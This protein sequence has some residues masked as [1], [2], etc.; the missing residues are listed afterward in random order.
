MRHARGWTLQI[1]L[2][3]VFT[4]ITSLIA[5]GI[6]WYGHRQMTDLVALEVQ[7]D[8]NRIGNEVRA[9]LDE[10]LEPASVFLHTLSLTLHTNVSL[11]S[12]AE[13]LPPLLDALQH[14][15]PSA[16]SF[17][18]GRGDGSFAFVQDLTI[19]VP[20]PLEGQVPA[21]AA[22]ALEIVRID[23]GTA[24][25]HWTLLDEAL[26]PIA[27]IEP[28][29]TTFDPRERTWFAQA[30]AAEGAVLTEVYSF[31]H[32][33][34]IGLTMARRS[35]RLGDAIL[36]LDILLTELDALLEA[37]R[38]SPSMELFLFDSQGVLVAH[39]NGGALREAA[40]QTAPDRLP[41]LADLGEPRLTQLLHL[42]GEK[43][44][45]EDLIELEGRLHLVRFESAGRR[46]GDLVLTMAYPYDEIV[47]PADS[48]RTQMR[49]GGFL[50]L[51]VGFLF[52][53][54][55][56]R[57]VARPLRR[58]T[59]DMARAVRFDF[60]GAETSTS[61]VREIRELSH[62]LVTLK[63]ALRSFARYVPDQLVRNLLSN[64]V[65]PALGGQRQ[66]ITVLFSDIQGFTAMAEAMEPEALTEK[67][68]R[69]FSTLGAAVLTNEGTIDKYIGDAM[70]AFWNA[71]S[72]QPDHVQ[73]AC[74]A[75]L[76]AAAAIE[77]LNRAFGAESTAAMPT[78][79]GLHTGEAVVGNIGSVDR[80]NYT[81]LGHTV[82]LA[83]RTE[84]LN[85]LFGT[86]ILAT[87]AIVDAAG[88]DFVFRYVGE[89]VPQGASGPVR[90]HEL[91]AE[92]AG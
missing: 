26:R 46:L 69:Y 59:A 9:G 58:V 47:G 57:Q 27:E 68:S 23:N 54:L 3:T 20:P 2:A 31:A 8:F 55:A 50:A 1:V 15:F 7:A 84:G 36:G 12:L 49:L 32:L 73:R 88:E 92:R 6:I 19:G 61:P 17:F 60:A 75:A 52:V 33:P 64:R 24:Q 44:E 21:G 53:F 4:I 91:I 42:Y 79:F 13:A 56:A 85:K 81:A 62:T 78:R 74:R 37:Q 66:A 48:I 90:F 89:A 30:V 87:Q 16:G 76:A 72:P 5:G 65:V 35:E 40:R 71:P 82:N 43:G 80:M 10:E 14:V 29:S 83:A 25:S 34:D 18:V 41:R 86:T 77:A 45:S 67:V 38:A 28:K 70:M 51:A 39:P 11:Q 22:Y 63:G